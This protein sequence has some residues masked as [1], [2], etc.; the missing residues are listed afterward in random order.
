MFS[1]AD[2][3]HPQ[4]PFLSQIPCSWGAVYFPEHWRAFHEY[5]AV[6]LSGALPLTAV[7]APG[8]RSNRW[9][10]SWKKYFIE[11]VF[12]RGHVMLY[13]NFAAYRSLSTNH[14]EVGAHVR[15]M[16]PEA[17]ERKRRLY[18]LPLLQAQTQT[19]THMEAGEESGGE[20]AAPRLVETGLLDL[21]MGS[22]PAWG[23]AAG[24]G[25]LW[26]A[27]VCRSFEGARC[28]AAGRALRVW[29]R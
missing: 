19:Q 15:A 2:L 13:P 23:G 3:P 17:Y 8:V 27:D 10:R 20:G 25:P 5:L 29:R 9:T 24:D 14:L 12:L 11:L 4:T 7:V 22:M 1:A 16:P 21:P 28:A 26:A 18:R 6:R